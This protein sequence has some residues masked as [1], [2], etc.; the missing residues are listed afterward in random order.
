MF[1]N[2]PFPIPIVTLVLM[3]IGFSLVY[4]KIQDR[5][6]EDSEGER[7]LRIVLYSVIMLVTGYFGR[8]EIQHYVNNPFHIGE[9]V[10][11]GFLD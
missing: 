2:F 3:Y 5:I 6:K 4:P 9:V 7:W 10:I 1:A 11:P 8:K